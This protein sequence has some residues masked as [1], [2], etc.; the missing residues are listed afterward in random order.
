MF[1][2]SK[3]TVLPSRVIS[4]GNDQL[5]HVRF[6]SVLSLAEEP[7]ISRREE[8]TAQ[9]TRPSRAMSR[10]NPPGAFQTSRLFPESEV[11]QI[12]CPLDQISSPCGDQARLRFV[13]G[14]VTSTLPLA[15]MTLT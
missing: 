9:S 13:H 12:P 4:C 3:R 10:T 6:R 15:S 2:S 5:S 1:C 14:P 11:A 7:T 8:S